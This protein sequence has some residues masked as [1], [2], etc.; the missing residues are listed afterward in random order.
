M[1]NDWFSFCICIFLIFLPICWGSTSA[2]LV[3][4]QS[5][6]ASTLKTSGCI[7]YPDNKTEVEVTLTS[8]IV[9]KPVVCVDQT[10]FQS[11]SDANHD[12]SGVYFQ[13]FPKEDNGLKI[14]HLYPGLI[15]QDKSTMRKWNC[16]TYTKNVCNNI[17]KTGTEWCWQMQTAKTTTKA[18]EKK[19]FW[20]CSCKCDFYNC[21]QWWLFHL[22]IWQVHV[23]YFLSNVKKEG[24]Y[25]FINKLVGC[26]VRN[27]HHF[28]H[29][30]A[31]SLKPNALKLLFSS[32]GNQPTWCICIHTLDK[33]LIGLYSEATEDRKK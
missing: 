33:N 12:F 11:T 7:K 26:D 23:L 27:S 6:T 20:H 3:P 16:A 5:A 30:H 29:K 21:S 1:L 8:C 17:W 19:D 10:P 24:I 2:P 28:P 25:M 14:I 22:R 32:D 15:K 13:R 9:N 4:L 18:L 31:L